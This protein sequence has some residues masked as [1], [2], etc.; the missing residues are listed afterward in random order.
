M[1][2]SAISCDLVLYRVEGISVEIVRVAYGARR[3]EGLVDITTG[4]GAK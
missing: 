2:N 4:T 1:C 3:L